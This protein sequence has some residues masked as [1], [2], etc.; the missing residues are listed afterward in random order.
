MGTVD[1]VILVCLAPSLYFGLKNGLV[2]QI[3]SFAVIYLGITLSLRFSGAAEPLIQEYL[4][5]EGF[6]A[7]FLAFVAIFGAVALVLN[8]LGSIIE[9]AISAGA[10]GF[11]NRVLGLLLSLFIF[12]LLTALLVSLAD[13]LN[14]VTG[15]IPEEKIAESKLYPLMLDIAKTFFPYLKSL[16]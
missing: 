2:K 9:K 5:L 3:I 14:E 6:W 12:V 1:I 8:L 13:S 11:L 10:T 4:H 7:K 16:F 15:I